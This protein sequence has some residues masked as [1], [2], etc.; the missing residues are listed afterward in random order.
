[1]I[2]QGTVL[3]GR[4]EIGELI[5]SGGM[6]LVFRA[7]DLQQHRTVAIKML[8]E[9]YADDPTFINR[10]KREGQ[11]VAAL[12]HPNIVK[13]YAVCQDEDIFYLVMELIEGRDLKQVLQS[14]EAPYSPREL[15]HIASQIC[16]AIAYAH[17]KKIIHRDIKPHNIIVRPD[18]QIKVTDFGIARAA[19]EA[20]MTHTGS[21]MGTVH[22]LSPEQAKGE[23]ADQRSDIYSLGVLL[24]EMATGVLPYEG[25]SPIS[26]AVQKI[27]QDPAPP[28]EANPQ[29][30]EAL[31]LVIM[32]AMSRNP[33]RRYQS[34]LQ[35]KDD[36]REA[37]FNHRVI[38]AKATESDPLE[39]T[40]QTADLTEVREMIKEK[41]QE[42]MSGRTSPGR[43]NPGRASNGG[44][45]RKQKTPVWLLLLLFVALAAGGV[46]LGIKASSLF[47]KPSVDIPVPDVYNMSEETARQTLEAAG[48]KVEVLES[49]VRSAADK[50]AVAHQ[51]PAANV[52]VKSGSTVRLTLSKGAEPVLVP[53]LSGMSEQAASVMLSNFGLILSEEVERVNDTDYPAGQ[54]IGQDPAPET[55]VQ[56][57]ATVTIVVSKGPQQIPVQS[58]VGMTISAAEG[59]AEGLGIALE[60]SYEMNWNYAKDIIVRQDPAGGSGAMMDA[61]SPIKVV[62]SLGPGPTVGG[63]GTGGTGSE[64]GGE[65]GAGSDAGSGNGNGG[66]IDE[67]PIPG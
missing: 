46:Y 33:K 50:D 66:A 65:G 15:Y 47:Y 60:A 3:S 62:V 14:R 18:G 25:E 34:V 17:H 23:I 35:L 67:D 53:D 42:G 30:S 22:Y 21:I 39:D 44:K 24:Y 20:T 48:L 59:A 36:L 13:V 51:E 7:Q 45:K 64:N 49:R 61:N 11:S 29:L 54:I 57:G 43:T 40:L 63:S 9:Q 56:T 12:N 16:D 37:C 27:Q 19:S 8:R 6:S 5:G 32:K 41:E 31:E 10:F 52:P 4:Y 2:Q 38:Y 1:M 55:Q 58:F 28:A 26:V